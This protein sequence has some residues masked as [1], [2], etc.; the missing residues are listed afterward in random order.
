MVTSKRS[1][2]S[3]RV[4]YDVTK[5]TVKI[6]IGQRISKRK[7]KQAKVWAPISD[8]HKLANKIHISN[9]SRHKVRPNSFI[10][11]FANLACLTNGEL[12]DIHP[13]AF[14]ARGHGPN[15]NILNHK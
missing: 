6:H 5:P 11:Q 14:A 9:N 8:V 12:S 4:L 13:L 7:R 15:P 3:L 1:K 2:S 10:N